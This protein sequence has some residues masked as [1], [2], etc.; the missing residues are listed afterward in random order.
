M[1]GLAL[2]AFLAALPIT[3]PGAYPPGDYYLANDITIT[4][5]TALT[6]TA[7][8]V[9]DRAEINLNGKTIHCVTAL[10]AM[11]I[12]IG[13]SGPSN[14]VILGGG[15]SWI[16]GC[17]MGVSSSRQTRV[18]EVI[19]TNI[20]YIAMDLSGPSSRA[21][22]NVV[23]NVSGVTDEAYSMAITVRGSGAI[24]QGN[25][26]HN[27]Y[28]QA[29]A[30]PELVGEGVAIILNA[31]ATG[32][33]VERNFVSNDVVAPDTIGIFSGAGAG[34]TIRD[35]SIRNFDKGIQMAGASTVLRNVLFIG[36]ALMES[37]GISATPVGT[38]SDSGIFGYPAG[39]EIT[40][41]PLGSGNL[42]CA[43]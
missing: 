31:A 40:G 43:P 16:D 22:G 10:N 42:F 39:Q 19:F 25:S 3:A 6:F 15:A 24:I 32:A 23:D 1:I 38:V 41:G 5:G 30:A 2:A 12:G 27:L 28:R 8:T 35:N 11:T 14:L 21:I 17:R 9:S 34:H 36:R 18:Q 29:G 26:F 4:S 13:G 20:K 7:A 33:L 37:I